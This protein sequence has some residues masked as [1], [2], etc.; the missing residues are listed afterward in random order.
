MHTLFLMLRALLAYLRVL[1][2]SMK[3]LSVGETQATIRV[4][5]L[6]PS[7]SWRGGGGGGGGRDSQI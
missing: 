1:S 7:E 2:V 3:S 4:L 5:L 6:P